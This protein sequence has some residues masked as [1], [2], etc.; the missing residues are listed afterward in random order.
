MDHEKG[1]AETFSFAPEDEHSVVLY[2]DQMTLITMP[3]I[4]RT[5]EAT[6]AFG[7]NPSTMYTRT[8]QD[9]AGHAVALGADCNCEH[10]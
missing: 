7:E 3:S 1:G 10:Q 9:V 8:Y 4:D 6:H 2:D 5:T